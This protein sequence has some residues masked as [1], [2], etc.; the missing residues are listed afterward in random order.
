MV[1]IKKIFVKDVRM[2]GSRVL[3]AA[4]NCGII[5]DKSFEA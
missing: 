4:I 1:L 3:S 2:E 5:N